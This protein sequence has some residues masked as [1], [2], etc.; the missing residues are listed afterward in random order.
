MFT[1]F[2]TALLLILTICF[3]AKA[4]NC[5]TRTGNNATVIL[6][7]EVTSG[8]ED[9]DTIKAYFKAL[10][11]GQ[12]TYRKGKP[13][14]LAV[15]GD[16]RRTKAVDGSPE[17]RPFTFAVVRASNE[18]AK[19]KMDVALEDGKQT[20]YE[21]DG[22]YIAANIKVED[23]QEANTSAV[24][25]AYVHASNHDGNA[26]SGAIDGDM[27]TRWSA[28]GARQWL[29][30]DLGQKHRLSAV[31]IAWFRGNQRKS[32]FE[33]ETSADGK[34]W[35]QILSE[36]SS[37]RTSGLE[38]YPVA[39]ETRFLRIVGLGNTKNRWNSISEI[40][41]H[42]GGTV[43]FNAV[44]LAGGGLEATG[45]SLVEAMEETPSSYGLDKNYPNP[46]NPSTVITYRLP[47]ASKVTLTVYNSNGQRVKQL[48]NQHQEAGE[49]R[50][51]WNGLDTAG[52]PVGSGLYA[53]QIKAGNFRESRTMMLMK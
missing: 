39:V 10:C 53:Y 51:N 47:E 38:R 26:P 18:S 1:K 15:W 52:T 17:G 45:S 25:V 41:I 32:F 8:L 43:Q 36:T 2:T 7:A 21:R 3:Q 42:A 37:G 20:V 13:V 16:N 44:T 49:Y 31:E 34:N 4:E 30:L 22:I 29:R 35:K 27:T 6:P 24:A 33:I 11:V 40:Q 9:G 19:L 48:V 14:A 12:A 50:I 23:A 28:K 46:F 5:K